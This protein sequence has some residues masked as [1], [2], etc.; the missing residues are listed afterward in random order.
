VTTPTQAPAAPRRPW[1]LIGVGCAV[2]VAGLLLPRLFVPPA[3]A[4]EAGAS[5]VD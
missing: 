5:P 2:V 4:G 1:A 3:E